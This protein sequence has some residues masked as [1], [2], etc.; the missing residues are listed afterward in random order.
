MKDENAFGYLLICIGIL[1]LLMLASCQKPCEQVTITTP[2]AVSCDAFTDDGIAIWTIH[3]LNESLPMTQ[4]ECFSMR[5]RIVSQ[6]DT[7]GVFE[8]H[9]QPVKIGNVVQCHCLD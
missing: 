5:E 6:L 8:L 4:W 7:I 1:G 3:K 2:A 9:G